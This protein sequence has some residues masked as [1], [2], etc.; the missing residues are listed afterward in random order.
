MAK[1]NLTLLLN[2]AQLSLKLVFFMKK[3]ASSFSLI[4][5]SHLTLPDS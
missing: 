5:F 4:G 2:G 1:K 3:F